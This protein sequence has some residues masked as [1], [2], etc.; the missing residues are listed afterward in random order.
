[1]VL[2][3]VPS[4]S[5]ALGALHIAAV[6]LDTPAIVVLVLAIGLVLGV[7]WASR[8]SV[9]NRYSAKEPGLDESGPP[10]KGSEK[11]PSPADDALRAE[12]E[13]FARGLRKRP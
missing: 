10:T 4:G 11:R 13:R 1:M 3:S 7:W 6:T 9:I 5:S 2:L 8:P 12:A